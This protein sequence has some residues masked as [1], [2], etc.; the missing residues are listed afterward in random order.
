MRQLSHNLP[1]TSPVQA[2]QVVRHTIDSIDAIESI[3]L[4]RGPS[5][6]QAAGQRRENAAGLEHWYHARPE[7]CLRASGSAQWL[8]QLVL[9]VLTA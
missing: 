6:L 1:I 7:R 9:L 2:S 5:V 3:E 8:F 4:S